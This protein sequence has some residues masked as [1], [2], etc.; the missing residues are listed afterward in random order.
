MKILRYLS[1]EILAHMFA[2][3]VV[4]LAIMLSGR[5]VKYL[6]EAAVGDL[7]ASVVLPV[8]FYR[9]PGFLE[10]ILP[11]GIFIGILMSYGRLYVESEMVVL[12]ACGVSPSR[13]AVYTVVPALFGM[14]LVAALSFYFTPLGA[15]RSTALL[16]DPEA[17]QGLQALAEG[18]FQYQRSDGSVSYAQT[19]AADTGIMQ[20]VFISQRAEDDE[21]NSR[22]SIIYARE[23][24]II[25]DAESGARYLE[26]RDG[27]RY[28]GL[29]G[30]L[31]FEVVTF[32]RF[33]EL[34]PEREGG[35]RDTD[36]VDARPTLALIGS[37]VPEE[38]AA[39]HWRLS[40][41]VMVPIVA[42][43]A[44]CMSRTDHRRGRYIKMVPAFI[45]YLV[46][47]F[48]LVRGRALVEE[49]DAQ[50]VV[51]WL[52]HLAFTL[53]ALAMLYVPRLRQSLRHRR[54]LRAQA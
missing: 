18:R 41:P 12:S 53:L 24:Q 11:L 42:V 40:L 47:L 48:L 43:I 30:E 8:I 13:L 38:R 17:S 23:G 51:L 14:V 37:D 7:A 22:M 33:G 35:I 26:L 19:I 5:F 4:L 32:G 10:L 27:S 39:L 6:A 52:V 16:E 28:D 36:R 9:I 25:V 20:G 46:Y 15:A 44:L 3:T 54:N 21:G 1:R 45:V 34:I 50:P 2:V 31:D 49:G 29:P